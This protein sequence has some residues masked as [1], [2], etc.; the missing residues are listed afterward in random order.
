MRCWRL[1]LVGFLSIFLVF[2]S[3]RTDKYGGH[4]NHSTGEYHYHHGHSAH[5]HYPDNKPDDWCQYRDSQKDKPILVEDKDGT[6][7]YKT[8]ASAS[9][10]EI[11]KSNFSIE[12]L[13]IVAIMVPLLSKF[14]YEL[15]K[16]QK[17]VK[18]AKGKY[19]K[20]LF[21]IIGF[22]VYLDLSVI[23]CFFFR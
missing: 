22:L 1:L 20:I 4:T 2:H 13:A 5:Y 16:L 21:A 14:I 17:E 8:M 7:K 15:C 3:G 10:I 12:K 23:F 9:F 11:F 18:I 6:S 19:S